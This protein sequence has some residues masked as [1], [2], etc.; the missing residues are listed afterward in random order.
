[1]SAANE[2]LTINEIA[3]RTE[4]SAKTLRAYL[5]R[6]HARASEQKN[7]RWGNAKNAYAL[8]VKLTNELLDHFTKSEESE[9]S[10]ES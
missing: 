4:T 8:N 9:E 3:E 6:E 5:R 2:A 10:E 7:A 1:M